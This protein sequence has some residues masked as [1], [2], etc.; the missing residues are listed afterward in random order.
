MTPDPLPQPLAT[1][2]TSI[3]SLGRAARFYPAATPESF[4]LI[5]AGLDFDPSTVAE[6]VFLEDALAA[7]DSDA[8]SPCVNLQILIRLPSRTPFEASPHVIRFCNALTQCLG[9]GSILF[10]RASRLVHFRALLAWPHRSVDPVMV[11]EILDTADRFL[12]AADPLIAAIAKGETSCEHA[13]LALA[14]KGFPIPEMP[15]HP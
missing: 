2:A 1:L 8:P 6:L 10:N 9:R 13:I 14:Q 12:E 4:G 7:L 5:L 3:D 11:S 15:A